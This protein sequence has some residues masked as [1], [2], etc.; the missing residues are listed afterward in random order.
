[1]SLQ[2]AHEQKEE[3]ASKAADALADAHRRFAVDAAAD[4][5]LLRDIVDNT[6][7]FIGAVDLQGVMMETNAVSLTR[8]GVTRGDVIGRPFWDCY[9]W[10][11]DQTRRDELR[12]AI[13]RAAHGE[14]MRYDTQAVVA[15]GAVIDIDFALAPVRDA[16]GRVIY[17]VASAVDVTERV[18]TAVALRESEA[19]FRELAN[20]VPQLVWT[21]QPDGTVDYYNDKY[22][23]YAG[24][25][26]EGDHYVW[27]LVV[28]P[29]DRERTN[30]A[31]E[32]ALRTG[33]TYMVEHRVALREGGYRWLLS[34]GMPV[35]NE[36]GT[37]VK[38]YGTATDI[39]SLKEAAALK[40]EFMAVATHELK[41]PVTSI[42]AYAQVLEHRFRSVG[43]ERS[44][45]LVAK[46]DT[47]LE[48]LNS[49]IGDVLDATRIEQGKLPMRPSAVALNELL[50][51]VAEEVERSSLTHHVALALGAECILHVDR[52]RIGQV[53]TNLLTNAIKYSPGSDTV[54]VRTMHVADARGKRVVIAVRDT[55]LGM[56]AEDVPHVFDRFFRA[57]GTDRDTYPG[58]GLG[59]YI[60]KEIVDRHGGDIWAESIPGK[61]STFYVALPC[62]EAHKPQHL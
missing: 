35:R 9:W 20:S 33:D 25:R 38:W 50:H 54:W 53:F 42:K 27:D 62:G 11:H 18:R 61:G 37:V 2:Y 36:A 17:L 58:L 3:K 44:A 10:S 8:A 39:H 51:E 60:S 29:D 30:S 55:G 56:Q 57:H 12:E 45:A 7:T 48:K 16:E 43:D 1:M 47:Q 6:L 22:T 4:G 49:I 28:H 24:I 41:T 5:A 23:L 34:R 40:E 26:R 14:Y 32:Q 52:E 13:R 19:K 21:A 59:L 46:I 31:W 15:G